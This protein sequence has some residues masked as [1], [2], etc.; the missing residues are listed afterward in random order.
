MRR[1]LLL[2]VLAGLWMVPSAPRALAAT[3][4]DYWD[5][6]FDANGLNG[7]VRAIAIASNG[8]VY[9]GGDFTRAGDIDTNYIARWDGTNWLSLGMGVNSGVSSLAVSSNG[10]T[11]IPQV[12][13]KKCWIDPVAPPQGRD[14]KTKNQ[15]NTVAVEHSETDLQF[16]S[17]ARG[18]HHRADY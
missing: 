2:L 1:L 7:A 12:L 6:T 11:A 3:D 5:D 16:Y 18:S 17:A 4:D 9:V 10:F 8:D 13:R 14:E 15:S